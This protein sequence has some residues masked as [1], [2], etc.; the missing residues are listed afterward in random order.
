M[1]MN[2]SSELVNLASPAEETDP[3]GGFK[4]EPM[5][6]LLDQADQAIRK[7]N[8]QESRE[9]LTR[10]FEILAGT[11]ADRVAV[12][13]ESQFRVEPYQMRRSA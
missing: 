5:D 9:H 6:R 7:G 13:G 12:H 11:Q 2:K 1:E 8:V 10:I 4:P 3:P